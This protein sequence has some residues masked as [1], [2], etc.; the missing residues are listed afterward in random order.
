MFLA[1]VNLRVAGVVLQ[2]L[3]SQWQIGLAGGQFVGS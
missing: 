3:V 1:I 2:P